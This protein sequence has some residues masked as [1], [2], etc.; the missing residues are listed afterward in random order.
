[1]HYWLEK[2]QIVDLL[3]CLGFNQIEV[4]HDMPGHQNGPC[5]S[6]FARRSRD[7]SELT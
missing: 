1:M 6:L 3:K 7:Q 2:E 4:A 5:F